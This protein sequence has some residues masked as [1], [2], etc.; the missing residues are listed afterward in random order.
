MLKKTL[1]VAAVTAFTT[2]S[3]TGTA[4][5]HT[6]HELETSGKG[7]ILSGNQLL[8]D[9]DVPVNLCGNAIAVLGIANAGCWHSGAVVD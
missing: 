2:L 5:A 1:A 6:E 3:L 8:V 9:A 4:L 7:G